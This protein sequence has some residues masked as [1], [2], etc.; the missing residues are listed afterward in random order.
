MTATFLCNR[1]LASDEDDGAIVR[2][3]VATKVT[4]ETVGNDGNTKKKELKRRN[5]LSG[6]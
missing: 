4:S 5:T 2:E 1:W 3:L 6:K